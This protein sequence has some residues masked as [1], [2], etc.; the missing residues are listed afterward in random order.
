M[1]KK[2]IKFKDLS[3][4]DSKRKSKIEI[5]IKINLILIFFIHIINW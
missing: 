4:K 5:K 2:I 3:T 1:A